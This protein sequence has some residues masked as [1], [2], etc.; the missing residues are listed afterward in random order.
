MIKAVTGLHKMNFNTNHRHG[1][2]GESD[3][4]FSQ[5]LKQQLEQDDDSA[6]SVSLHPYSSDCVQVDNGTAGDC[7]ALK[8][9]VY[10][11]EK[12]GFEIFSSYFNS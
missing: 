12:G 6:Y 8:K 3:Q 11:N 2:R 1:H 5:I 7:R 9:G 4:K 10:K